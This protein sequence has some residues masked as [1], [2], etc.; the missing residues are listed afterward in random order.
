VSLRSFLVVVL[1]L[2]FGASAAVGVNSLRSP[3]PAEP[4]RAPAE[5]VTVVVAAEDVP[6]FTTLSATMLKTRDFPKELA[7]AGAATRIE[8]VTD[9]ATLA[10]LVKD[11][12]VLDARLG[13]RGAGRGVA[14]ALPEGMGAYTIQTPNVAIGVA[15]LVIPGN[16]VDVL[17]TTNGDDASTITLLQSAEVLAVDQQTD[18]PA[19]NKVDANQMRSVTL[20]VTPLQ[21]QK[22]DLGQNKGTLHLLLRNGKD[23]DP[24]KPQRVTM[25]DIGLIPEPPKPAPKDPERVTPVAT[26]PQPPPPARIRTLRGTQGGVVELD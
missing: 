4:P 13:Q 17:L 15:G 9:R 10:T 21:A 12:P 2:I 1:A 11:E 24:V 25:T 26:A 3:A 23:N 6:R 5:T 14:P 22:L 16:K 18:A 7:P 20:L 8:D 19:G